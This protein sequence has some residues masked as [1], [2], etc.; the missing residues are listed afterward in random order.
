MAVEDVM[1]LTKARSLM[2]ILLATCNQTL[3]A[4]EA[5]ANVLDTSMTEDLRRMIERTEGELEQITVKLASR[6]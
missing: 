5:V 2:I 1:A 3:L 4:L 6:A